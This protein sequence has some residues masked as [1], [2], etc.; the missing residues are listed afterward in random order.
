[1]TPANA[2]PSTSRRIALTLEY[3]GSAFCG[4]QKQK[5]PTV[6]T[7][8]EVLETALARVSDH[9]VTVAC[10]GRTD[11][12]VHATGQIVHFDCLTP[13]E[14]K[15][16][17]HG[18]NSLL[19]KEVRVVDASSVE[20]T[21]HARFSAL[22]RRYCYLISSASVPSGIFQGKITCIQRPLDIEAMQR[23]AQCLVGEHDFS[24][25]RAAGCQSASA[26]RNVSAISV[27]DWF[28]VT[29]IDIRA[30]AFLQHMVR[31]ISGSLIDVGKGKQR[32][33]WIAEVLESK[34]RRKA[35]VT[36]PPDGLYLVEVG[37]D[38]SALPGAKPR[39]PLLLAGYE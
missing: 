8:Q 14:N 9:S 24:A 28:G 39:F 36:A 31:N 6:N 10:A 38:E 34:D 33:A 16:W 27:V 3:D 32:E 21:F 37:Y 30:N 29:V 26:N 2:N 35:G 13:R 1:M 20:N 18:V 23:A 5:T 22:D 17:I 7:V 19:P 11:A 25:F 15:A 4:W 12:G